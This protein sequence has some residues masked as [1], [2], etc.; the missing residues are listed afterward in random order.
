MN[1]L[2]IEG[3]RKLSGEVRIHGAKNAVLPILA[4]TVLHKG[5][6]VIRDCPDLKDVRSSIAILKN[7]GAMVRREG[8]TLIVDAS[9]ITNDY[10][11]ENLML[12]MRSS[13]MFLGAIVGRCKSAKLSLPGGCELGQRPIA[14]HL[15]AVR[16]MNVHIEEKGGY[17]YCDTEKIKGA[18]IHLDFP[19][20]GATENIILAATLA[21]GD[22]LI[23][24][25]AKEPEIIDLANFLNSLGAKVQGAGSPVIQISGVDRLHDC[26]HKIIPDR[27]VS[28][29]YLLGAAMAGGEILLSNTMPEHISAILSV[30]SDCG[31]NLSIEKDKIRLVAPETLRPIH[32]LRTLPYPGFPTDAQPPL[33][34]ALALAKGVSMIVETI[35]ENR[36][37]LAD[38]LVRMGADIT[39]DGRVAVIRGVPS[40][41]GANVNSMDLRGGAGLVVAGLAAKGVTEVGN[42]FHIDRGYQNIE[43]DLSMLGANIKRI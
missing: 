22:T 15:K 9:D 31:C 24:N 41:A 37:R 34:A 2:L 42:I 38:E 19:S 27:I 12:E 17:I 32:L 13:I 5:E 39:V 1:K 30:L 14:M 7:L 25:A 21:E 23:T 36:F 11:P 6:S 18:K 35:F 8:S 4:A 29:T 26:V 28:A 33:M 10:I 40:L 20:V 43:K 16:E 3:G